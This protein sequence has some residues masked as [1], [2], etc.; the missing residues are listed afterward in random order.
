MC[1]FLF[2]F[3]GY[4]VSTEVSIQHRIAW[5]P[6]F[7]LKPLI[8]YWSERKKNPLAECF[9]KILSFHLNHRTR[10]QFTFSPSVVTFLLQIESSKVFVERNSL[11]FCHCKWTCLISISYWVQPI[12]RF[13]NEYFLLGFCFYYF[14]I[15]IVRQIAMSRNWKLWSIYSAEIISSCTSFSRDKLIFLF[16]PVQESRVQNNVVM[17]SSVHF[18]IFHKACRNFLRSSRSFGFVPHIHKSCITV[19][20]MNIE[21]IH[22]H[23]ELVMGNRSAQF[24][25]S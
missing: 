15:G 7:L 6:A 11:Y 4:V 2:P 16:C 23:V 1:F 10:Y 8:K 13:I 18:Q 20:V 9:C 12:S 5:R 22:V 21:I 19:E 25:K 17:I 24:R 3:T 14:K